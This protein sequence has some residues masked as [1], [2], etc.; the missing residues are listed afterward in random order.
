MY[1]Y[2]TYL[3][4]ECVIETGQVGAW[5]R[6]RFWGRN[7][8][9]NCMVMVMVRIGTGDGGGSGGQGK[10]MH[11]AARSE[12]GKGRKPSLVGIKQAAREDDPY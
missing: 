1:V 12:A 6:V 5:V 8:G 7:G 11:D 3:R 2:V 10:E 9:S 4:R